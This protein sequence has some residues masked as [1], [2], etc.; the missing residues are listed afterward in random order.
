MVRKIFFYQIVLFLFCFAQNAF[1]AP[2]DD[3]ISNNPSFS[4]AVISVSV[5]DLNTGNVI[6]QKNP[7]TL[8]HPASA[9]KVVTSA[10]ALDYLGENYKFKTSLYKSGSKVYLKVGADPLFSY[11]DMINLISQYKNKN[12]EA[13]KKLVIDDTITD[14]VSFGEG[15]QWDDNAS[16]Y[17]PQMSPYI[18]NRNLFMIKAFSDGKNIKIEYAPEYKEKIIN[19]LK[20]GEKTAVTMTRNLFSPQR[21]IILSGT[22]SG[23]EIV[24]IPALEPEKLYMNVLAYAFLT[25]DVS[26]N[27]VFSY[28]KVPVFASPEGVISHDIKDVLKA[29]LA[30]SDNLAAETLIKHAAAAKTDLP[31][32]TKEGLKIVKDFYRQNKVNINDLI[33]ADASGASMNDYVTS[34]FMTDALIVI[35]KNDTGKMFKNA[36]TDPGVGTFSGRVK[37][38]N[39]RIKVKT[40]TLA[41]TSAAIGYL[42]TNSGRDVVFAIMLDNLPKGVNAKKFEDE[43]IRAI[44]KQ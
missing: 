42:K 14:N 9:L 19:N 39:G 2:V 38:L 17:F 31:G 3:V 37:E 23:T 13:I 12:T 40:G 27:T 6:Y 24:Y 36:M 10:A 4:P 32:S 25:N 8:L 26:F 28:E 35:N 5:K 34:D 33:L 1:A 20:C 16:I 29:I 30:Y 44:A 7:K 43:I 18:I 11:E 21:E 15:W 22:V 41:N